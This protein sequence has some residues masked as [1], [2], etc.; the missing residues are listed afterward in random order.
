MVFILS[1]PSSS[2]MI[3]RIRYAPYAMP[4]R[5]VMTANNTI[6]AEEFMQMISLEGDQIRIFA[7]SIAFCRNTLHAGLE[8]FDSD[9]VY[10]EMAVHSIWAGAPVQA[11]NGRSRGARAPVKKIPIMILGGHSAST[12][13]D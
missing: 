13:R 1:V 12:D 10:F 4:I 7:D 9:P 3:Q 8:K 2:A 5:A 6:P 11:F